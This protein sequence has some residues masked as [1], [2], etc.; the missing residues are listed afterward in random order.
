[1]IPREEGLTGSVSRK[2]GYGPNRIPWECSITGKLATWRS[3][4]VLLEECI[5]NWRVGC[6]REAK[7]DTGTPD[8]TVPVR[9]GWQKGWWRSRDTRITHLPSTEDYYRV[10]HI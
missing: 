10:M 1:M 5:R 2:A 9:C 7:R 6:Q 3:T 4:A 8:R